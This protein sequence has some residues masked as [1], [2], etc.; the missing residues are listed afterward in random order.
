MYHIGRGHQGE[1]WQRW[2]SSHLN[3]AIAVKTLEQYIASGSRTARL[4]GRGSFK[5][6]P[7]RASGSM[8][9]YPRHDC[10]QYCQLPSAFV[11]NRQ[12]PISLLDRYLSFFG[13]NPDS[14][15]SVV[16]TCVDEDHP[17]LYEPIPCAKVLF[18]FFFFW[19]ERAN[20]SIVVARNSACLG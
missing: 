14:V 1:E 10:C 9:T 20:W 6:S 11:Y 18:F 12:T 4:N 5:S 19:M 3:V 16:P 2:V 17:P 15:C 7:A 8:G 13:L